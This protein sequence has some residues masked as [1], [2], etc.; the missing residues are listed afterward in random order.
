[1]KRRTVDNIIAVV[2]SW[3]N[4]KNVTRSPFFSNDMRKKK[5]H[6]GDLSEIRTF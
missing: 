3:F 2:L 6:T 5:L 1:M 4:Y